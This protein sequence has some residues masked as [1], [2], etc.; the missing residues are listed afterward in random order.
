[1]DDIDFWLTKELAS[2]SR[3]TYRKLADKLDISVNSVHKRVRAIVSAGIIKQYTVCLTQKAIPQV[4]VCICGISETAS[5]NDVVERLEKT[6]P[7][8]GYMW[9]AAITST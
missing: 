3:A 2:N 7:H 1:M 9:Q 4:W 5:V 6:L 8:S